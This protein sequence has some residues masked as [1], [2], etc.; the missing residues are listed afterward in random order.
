[1]KSR[2]QPN[3]SVSADHCHQTSAP[4]IASM[5]VQRT[6]DHQRKPNS[7]PQ[8][9]RFRRRRDGLLKNS[10]SSLGFLLGMAITP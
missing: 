4:A 5:M 2:P 1:M 8:K 10:L 3:K 6:G 7:P 9:E